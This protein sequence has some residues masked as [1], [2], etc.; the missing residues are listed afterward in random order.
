MLTRPT[1]KEI[2]LFEQ[3]RPTLILESWPVQPN[4]DFR[5]ASPTVM[6]QAEAGRY[7][8]QDRFSWFVRRAEERLTA[9]LSISLD[10]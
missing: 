3:A 10:S 4:G 1:S 9:Q 7:C 6:R 8:D 5:L 2:T